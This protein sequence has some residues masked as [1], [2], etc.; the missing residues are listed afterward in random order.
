MEDYTILEER[1]ISESE[2]RDKYFDF[3]DPNFEA[4]KKLKE[5]ITKNIKIKDREKAKEEIEGLNLNI[6]EDMIEKIIDINP[7]SPDQV[8]AILSQISFTITDENARKIIS[9]LRKYS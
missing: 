3:L 6:R 2:I 5:H 8:K 4:A 9:V 7:I 1:L